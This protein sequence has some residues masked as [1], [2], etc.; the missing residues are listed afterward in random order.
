LR[1]PS[2]KERHKMEVWDAKRKAT[3]SALSDSGL[4]L[5]LYYSRDRD[6]VFVK[7]SCDETHLRQVAEM[8]R[9][10]LEMK[11]QYLSA[12]AEY[13]NDFAGRREL[14]YSD[15][16]V[17]SH[18]FKAHVDEDEK[19]PRSD[20]IFRTVDRIQL[21][22]YI[23]RSS[24]HNC[25]GVDI[26]QMMHDGDVSHYYPLHENKQL[27]NMDIHWWKCFV[28]GTD[29]DKV[30]DYFGE[31]IGLYF[32]FMSHINKWLLL[33][34]L[35]GLV[36]WVVDLVDESP[37]NAT[38]VP[39][40]ICTG[41]WVML[42]VHSWRRLSSNYCLRWGTLGM[43]DALE[44]TRPEFRGVSRI[45]PVTGRID[46]YYPWSE[47]IFKVITSWAV[48]TVSLIVMVFVIMCLF[49]LRHRL[50]QSGGRLQFQIINAIVVEI[51]NNVFTSLAKWLTE[52]ENHRAYSE[53]A[54]HLLAKTVVFKFINSYISLYYIAFMKEHSYLFGMPMRC[55]STGLFEKGHDCLND[56]GS[57]LGIFMLVRLILSNMFELCYPAFMQW[58][59]GFQEGRTFQTSIFTNPLT[60]MPDLSTAEKQSKKE[61]FD[62]YEDM[63]EVLINFGYTT[64]FIVAA[65]WVPF[66]ALI[67]NVFECF[68]D[69]KKL[70]HLY[71][72]PFP[73]LTSN[74]EPWDTAFDVFGMLA[75]TTNAAVTIFASQTFDHWTHR[76][77][78]MLFIAV[79]HLLVFCRIFYGL[80]APKIPH[81]IKLLQMQQQVILHK[82]LNLGGEEEVDTD[83]RDSAMRTLQNAPFVY[84][85]DDE[86]L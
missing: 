86:N 15:R 38:L 42:F 30:R 8:K 73:Q 1:A 82:H 11:P 13:K 83:A 27:K 57:Q 46:R 16:C 2:D 55:A 24:D 29:I 68:L 43:G 75:M 84:D 81:G 53:F 39:L 19:Y 69:Q 47:R 85:Q 26:G 36:L 6:E 61:V 56:L 67:S 41:I 62:L 80:F 33:P 35:G 37:D 17:V 77:R 32:L 63:D 10:K 22:E 25:A 18:L 51:M 79:E 21:I 5:M 60:A 28:W 34:A 48:V 71:R 70:V 72:R 23:V 64:L 76:E 58:Y 40:T 20:A 50:A 31:R 14:G 52:R 12:F 7:I 9:H 4:I 74:N 44:P 49:G 54:N 59:R 45:N 65:P 66:V 3:I 78:I